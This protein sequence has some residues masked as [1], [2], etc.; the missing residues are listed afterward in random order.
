MKTIYIQ[1][2]ISKTVRDET[3]ECV[4]ALGFFDGVHIGHKQLIQ[5]AK[6]I[7]RQKKM[8]LAVMTFYPHP[9]DIVHSAQ[10]PMKYLTPLTVKEERF[11]NMGVEKLIVVKFDSAF[12][13]LPYEEFVKT[14]IIGFRCRHV[15]A[16]FDYHYGYMGQGNM[17]LLKEQG[18]N[19]FAVTTIPKIEHD[20]EKISSTAI[21]NLLKIGLVHAVPKYLDDYYEVRGKVEK[22]SS[23][24]ETYQFLEILVDKDYMLPA[25]GVYRIEV[26]IE[27]DIYEGVCQQVSQHDDRQ[28]LL[29]QLSNCNVETCGKRL[30]VRWIQYIFEKQ[31]VYEMSRYF[32][33]DE[34]AM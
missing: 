11:K 16:G 2:P 22:S 8:T 6:E 29:I 5:T 23:F 20:H 17:Q 12:A 14:Y 27:N 31:N 7:A 15:I 34:L 18:R 3:E 24:Y 4:L 9:R 13:R 1:H 30:K 19:Q 21:R 26:E 32:V 33:G 25:S 10:N 28:A